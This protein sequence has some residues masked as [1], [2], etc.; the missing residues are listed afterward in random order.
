[1]ETKIELQATVTK[2]LSDELYNKLDGNEFAGEID[3]LTKELE[4]NWYLKPE[5]KALIV[6][7]TFK[8]VNN[9]SPAH[10]YSLNADV[11]AFIARVEK[12]EHKEDEPKLDN[13]TH[14]E[15]YNFIKM[16]IDTWD[17]TEES[18]QTTGFA[19]LAGV[20][21]RGVVIES[22]CARIPEDLA[23]E[24]CMCYLKVHSHDGK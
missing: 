12:F 24:L 13:S 9:I 3:R 23:K 21:R 14:D 1:M 5:T 10:I 2:E 18:A 6:S 17:E 8:D 22:P 16:L 20:K 11:C 15:E 7:R 4:I 19:V